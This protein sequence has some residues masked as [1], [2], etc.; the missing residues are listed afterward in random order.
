[1]SAVNRLVAFHSIDEIMG[2]VLFFVIWR[3]YFGMSLPPLTSEEEYLRC[4]YYPFGDKA[5]VVF[6]YVQSTAHQTINFW[7]CT[8]L[9]SR[10]LALEWK[11]I[12][13]RAV[14]RTQW[15]LVPL[16][17]QYRSKWRAGARAS[18]A[19]ALAAPPA[20]AALSLLYEQY[21]SF[22]LQYTLYN[23]IKKYN[24]LYTVDKNTRNI[25]KTLT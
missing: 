10:A 17:R 12:A 23:I 9:I 2:E 13:W 25:T 14:D 18:A 1:V 6:M 5:W 4:F 21:D 3:C 16:E 20:P 15:I 22:T 7:L 24:F 8:E 11:C 19:P